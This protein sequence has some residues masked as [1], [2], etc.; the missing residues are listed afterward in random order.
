MVQ[1]A[2]GA[3]EQ[4]CLKLSFNLDFPVGAYRQV[5]DVAS[6]QSLDGRLVGNRPLFIEIPE[7]KFRVDISSSELRPGIRG[8][9]R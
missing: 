8:S 2:E 3:R 7:A 6:K 1:R 9:Q 5:I 4:R